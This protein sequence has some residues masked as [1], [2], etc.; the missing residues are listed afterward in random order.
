MTTPAKPALI[1][2][3]DTFYKWVFDK[4]AILDSTQRFRG[5]VQ[6]QDWPNVTIDPDG[7]LYLVVL[8]SNPIPEESRPYQTYYEHFVQWNWIWMGTD[9]QANQVAANRG[10][11]YR[12]QA[13]S[14]EKLRQCHFPGF[15]PKLAIEGY[16][17]VTGS[18]TFTPYSPVEMVKW[19]PPKLQTRVQDQ[20]G[21]LY[22]V[23]TLQISAYSTVNP[24]MNP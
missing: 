13:G 3:I 6:A 11:R 9:I 16:D 15:A 5:I 8:A 18:G 20:A 19:T 10:D 23:A 12:K 17:P 1:D 4:M 21:I 24:T 7:G 2:S 14:F 22:G